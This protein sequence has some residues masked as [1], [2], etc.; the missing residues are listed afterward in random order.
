[1]LHVIPTAFR[2]FIEILRDQENFPALRL[3][4]L[5]GARVTKRDVEQYQQHF[6]PDCI[7]LHNLSSTETGTLGRYFIDKSILLSGY[8]VPAGY[9]PADKEVVLLDE[10]GQ[11]VG[12]NCEGEIAV[13]SR[14]LALGY[15]RQPELTR[16]AFLPDPAGG[17][18]LFYRTGDLGRRGLDGCL[19]HLER[20]D[21]QV[22]IRGHRVEVAEIEDL[23]YAHT[24]VKEVVVTG[25]AEPTGETRLV[26]YVVPAQS[27]G[28]SSSELQHF[29]RA[30]L[31]AY[32][33]PSTF[34][35]LDAL[36]L[37]PNGKVNY[38]ALPVPDGHRPALATP[39][40]A[41]RTPLE[42]M[43]VRLWA[44]LLPL[45]DIG[46]FDPFLELG[47]HSLLAMRLIARIQDALQV[48]IPVHAF[49]EAA[50]VAELAVVIT[51]HMASQQGVEAV[52]P[53]LSALEELSDDEVH[54]RLEG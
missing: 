28:P 29:I 39:Y 33:V 2:H 4:Q 34:L 17:D 21:F 46:I 9:M 14:Y 25:H 35:W 20:K 54:R 45:E 7:L 11:E 49:L 26:A 13:K 3:I 27:P 32:M 53:F 51:Q 19:E 8:T 6:S 42:T 31:P 52:A 16:A 40:I 10:A 30:K 36:P 48:D 50:T 41:P 24:A 44:E 38:Q 22:Q 5:G 37:T 23:L 1:L 12:V 15:W 47:G 43:L 18:A